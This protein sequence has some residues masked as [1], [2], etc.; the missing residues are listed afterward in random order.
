MPPKK[1]IYIIKVGGARC[2]FNR[3]WMLGLHLKKKTPKM[4]KPVSVS[5]ILKFPLLLFFVCTSTMGNTVTSSAKG[6][7]LFGVVGTWGQVYCLPA[8]K[9]AT[10][11][12]ISCLN[13]FQK[14]PA[15]PLDLYGVRWIYAFQ[16]KTQDSMQREHSAESIAV[17]ES[18]VAA[19]DVSNF[20]GTVQMDFAY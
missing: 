18:L 13:L 3:R 11:A 12:F 10:T 15:F 9:G 7:R 14:V 19:A 1:K 16:K 17:G 4:P 2:S 6:L 20:V 5:A 8:K